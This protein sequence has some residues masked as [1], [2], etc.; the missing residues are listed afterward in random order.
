LNHNYIN[1]EAEKYN[2][3][4]EKA[5]NNLNKWIDKS[6]TAGDYNSPESAFNAYVNWALISLYF[7]DILKDKDFNI[8]KASIEK[9]MTRRGFLQFIPFQ[10]ELLR[11]Y[12]KE[13]KPVADLYPQIIEWTA[14]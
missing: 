12:Y 10:N 9:T 8:M 14:M 13:Q 6:K 7:S 3:L 1:P 5:F 2:K 11:L 4:I